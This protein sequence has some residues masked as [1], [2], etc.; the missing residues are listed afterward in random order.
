[1]NNLTKIIIV[2]VLMKMGFHC[3]LERNGSIIIAMDEMMQEET[4]RVK[5]SIDRKKR[6]V[7][8]YVKWMEEE[9]IQQ[10]K[11]VVDA[12]KALEEQKSFCQLVDFVD[13]HSGL[14]DFNLDKSNYYRIP[15]AI[16]FDVLKH[17][18]VTFLHSELNI[19]GTT[20][21]GAIYPVIQYTKEHGKDS[22]KFTITP[23][24]EYKKA[25]DMKIYA[26]GKELEV[27]GFPFPYD[28]SAKDI[29]ITKNKKQ[30]WGGPSK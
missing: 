7:S 25:A 5:S 3:F 18:I 13:M 8:S 24:R 9:E 17:K 21:F 16:R 10:K 11:T 27:T 14:D 26:K 23:F 20:V 12:F 6:I 2:L 4:K 29:M 28:G 22:I 15:S 30:L 19:S 1:M